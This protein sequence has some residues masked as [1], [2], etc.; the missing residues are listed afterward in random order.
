MNKT[1]LK[2]CFTFA[3]ILTS[4]IMI[5][6]Y[7]YLLITQFFAVY[8][9]VFVSRLSFLFMTL[10]FPFPTIKRFMA[11][12]F[13]FS[14]KKKSSLSY[15]LI[16]QYL[17]SEFS[18]LPLSFCSLL[19]FCPLLSYGCPLTETCFISS[20]LFVIIFYFLLSLQFFLK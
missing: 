12:I 3:N 9:E 11:L 20:E 2:I 1:L 6:L 4:F 13:I 17:P 14:G 19:R 15:T 7:I 18:L 5:S 16:F 10:V 8:N